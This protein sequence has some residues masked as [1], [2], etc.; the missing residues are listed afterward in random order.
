MFS[1]KTKLR[2]NASAYLEPGEE[3]CESVLVRVG[4]LQQQNHALIATDR[5]LYAFRL[6]W[7]GFSSIAEVLM[8]IPLERAEIQ[9]LP[10]RVVVKDRERETGRTWQ[11]LNFRDPTPLA[12]YVGSRSPVSTAR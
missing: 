10:R 11:R 6:G 5:N 4:T 9:V 1:R 12:E 2:E 8:K 3:V 7:P